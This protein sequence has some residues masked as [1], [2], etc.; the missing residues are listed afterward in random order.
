MKILLTGAS[1]FIGGHIKNAL[2]SSGHKVMVADRHHGIDF[3][4]MKEMSDWLPHLHDIDTVINS[5]GIIV[6]KTG[7]DFKHLHQIAPIALFRACEKAGVRRI[8]Q[9]SALGADEKA[10]TQ[11]QQSKRAADD[12]LRQLPLD[13]FVLRP[14]LVYGE[15]GA[16]LAMFQ[17]M[18]KLRVLVLA[19]GG[20]QRIQPVHV[21]DLVTTVIQCLKAKDTRQTLNVVGPFVLTFAEWLQ[22]MRKKQG[23]G[24]ATILPIPFSLVLAFSQ[25][26]RYVFPILHPDNLQMLQKGNT[27]DVQPLIEFLGR[28]PLSVDE[29]L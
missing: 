10:F 24:T 16:S 22:I 17:R 26:A 20:N 1:G 15:G 28:S 14:S 25:V 29:A 13:W 23:R 7:Q 6:E 18:A 3:N 19:D 9:I 21:S 11:Y 27:A 5:V 8:I 4:H 2:E 12:V